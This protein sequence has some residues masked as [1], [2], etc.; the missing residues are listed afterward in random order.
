[1]RNAISGQGH[2]QYPRALR[3]HGRERQPRASRRSACHSP[4]DR[5]LLAEG[6]G[7]VWFGFRRHLT[8][9]PHP[10]PDRRA[11]N[12]SRQAYHPGYCDPGTHSRKRVPLHTGHTSLADR[13]YPFAE[14]VR[15]QNRPARG[16]HALTKPQALARAA[17]RN[18]HLSGHGPASTLA[19]EGAT[20]LAEMDRG[21]S[22]LELAQRN[23]NL[24]SG[25]QTEQTEQAQ[26]KFDR[27]ASGW[28]REAVPRS[29]INL[30]VAVEIQPPGQHTPASAPTATYEQSSKYD[31]SQRPLRTIYRRLS[32]PSVSLWCVRIKGSTTVLDARSS[33]NCFLRIHLTQPQ[34]LPGELTEPMIRHK[35]ADR[36][37]NGI[38][39]IT[40]A[41]KLRKTN[42]MS[43]AVP[44]FPSSTASP[45]GQILTSSILG[46]TR[47]TSHKSKLRLCASGVT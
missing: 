28:R 4:A 25:N 13:R 12:R 27:F 6:G 45:F 38:K 43:R 9:P 39:D 20:I 37:A 17:A 35:P 42:A 11:N 18:Y 33:G 5:A 23:R 30:H 8:C 40:S 16:D 44:I 15:G 36:R 46:S 3:S 2:S 47:E 10:R 34:V 32:S 19:R 29:L 1:M 7:A 24:L 31:S 21:P 41:S 14:G 26:T 22:G